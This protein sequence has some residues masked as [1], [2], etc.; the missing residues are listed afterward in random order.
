MR[1]RRKCVHQAE[2]LGSL[3]L[4]VEEEMGYRERPCASRPAF[5][6]WVDGKGASSINFWVDCREVH[7]IEG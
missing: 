7:V 5:D 2:Y 4:P 6:T 3:E 1:Q